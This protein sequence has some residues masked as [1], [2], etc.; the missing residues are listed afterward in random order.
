M[1]RNS[2]EWDDIGILTK[3]EELKKDWIRVL[4]WHYKA[5]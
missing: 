5:K 2:Q 3:E 1:A 4:W